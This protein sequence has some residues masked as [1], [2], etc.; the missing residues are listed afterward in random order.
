M[1][2][3]SGEQLSATDDLKTFWGCLDQVLSGH[4]KFSGNVFWHQEEDK[5]WE[6]RQRIETYQA[7]GHIHAQV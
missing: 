1:L 2:S 5:D 7:D 4:P 6:S 3:W